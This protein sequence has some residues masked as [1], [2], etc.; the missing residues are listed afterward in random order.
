[1][2]TTGILR[3]ALA[4]GN[5]LEFRLPWEGIGTTP[6]MTLIFPTA[7]SLKQGQLEIVWEDGVVSL[8]SPEILRRYCPC[9]TCMARRPPDRGQRLCC[10]IPGLVAA[11][12]LQAHPPTPSDVSLPAELRIVQ[13][14]PVGNYAYQIA[15]SDGHDTGI[16]SLTFLRQ[17]GALSQGKLSGKEEHPPPQ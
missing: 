7:I 17:L 8:L 2:K 16:Y 9:A 1:M 5:F 12:S 13:V 15:F 11:E 14:K 3:I 4:L 6:A 10:Q